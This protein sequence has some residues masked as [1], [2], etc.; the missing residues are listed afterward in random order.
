MHPGHVQNLYDYSVWLE[1]VLGASGGYID[2]DDILRADVIDDG[3]RNALALDVD[4]HRLRFY[5]GHYLEF[6]LSVDLSL[7]PIDYS[8]HFAEP[9][10]S[11]IWRYDKH[12]GHEAQF[13]TDTHV[14]VG[15]EDNRQASPVVELDEVIDRCRA[16][17]GY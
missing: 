16:H 9:D 6:S 1:T 13:G 3:F 8:F 5:D 2:P 15:S 14:H 4:Q 17:L 11:L 12:L 10:D 7:E